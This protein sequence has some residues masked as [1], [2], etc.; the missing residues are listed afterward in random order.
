MAAATP[1]PAAAGSA[2]QRNG[3]VSAMSLRE[4]KQLLGARGVDYSKCIEKNEIRALATE[5]TANDEECAICLEVLQQPQRLPCGHRFCRGCVDGMRLHGAAEVQVCPLCRGPMPDAERMYLELSG[6][7]TQH[8]RWQ[9]ERWQ[10][11]QGAAGPA[12]TVQPPAMRELLHKAATLCREVLAIDPE[13]ACA[14][15]ALGYTQGAS[16]DAG[17]AISQFRAAIA[18]DPGCTGAHYSLGQLLE[19]C[20]DKAGAEASYRAAL[21]A[22]PELAAGFAH[23]KLGRLL[24]ERGDNAGAEASYRAAIAADPRSATVHDDLGVL[25]EDC[26][27]KAGAE[28]AYRAAI[29]ANPQ[30]ANAHSNL[31]NFLRKRGNLAGAEVACRAAI[32]T[33]PQHVAA[34]CNLGAVLGGG[35]DHAGAARSFVAA[36]KTD[37]SDAGAKA[38]LRMALFMMKV[39][40][41][42]GGSGTTGMVDAVARIRARGRLV[43]AHDQL[44]HRGG[45]NEI[46]AL[47]KDEDEGWARSDGDSESDQ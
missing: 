18:A 17:G 43:A 32:A 6:L 15:Y 31:G 11:G 33:D 47:L 19:E 35:G 9:R 5:A 27:D 8:E 30:Y 7:L 25:L 28:A 20:G 10:R 13:H 26:G 38:N 2:A 34:H 21:A 29:A 46:R 16:G 4:P 36:L 41:G 1:L 22:D 24:N 12:A 44:C 23:H 14:H 3:D 42:G 39:Q 37:P 40:R 45:N